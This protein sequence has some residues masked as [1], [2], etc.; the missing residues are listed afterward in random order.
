MIIGAC[1]KSA[2]DGLDEQ[3]DNV[4]HSTSVP[5]SKVNITNVLTMVRK[6]RE[7]AE[8]LDESSRRQG[9]SSDVTYTTVATDDCTGCQASA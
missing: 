9:G 4:L 8:P 1:C 7:S 2:S 5:R 6:I 3:G